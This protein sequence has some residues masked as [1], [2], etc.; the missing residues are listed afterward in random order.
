MVNERALAR[1]RSWIDGIFSHDD[2]EPADEI[3]AAAILAIVRHRLPVE[4]RARLLS[5]GD[6]DLVIRAPIDALSARLGAIV[7][8]A[9]AASA[10]HRVVVVVERDASGARFTIVPHGA[11]PASITAPVTDSSTAPR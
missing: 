4:D 7:S 6:L 10:R 2:R 8:D 3:N 11:A 5:D 1:L 9:L